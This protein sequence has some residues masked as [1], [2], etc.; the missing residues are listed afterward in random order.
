MEK[1]D[2]AVFFGKYC[3]EKYCYWPLLELFMYTLIP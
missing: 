2:E 1:N 3:E